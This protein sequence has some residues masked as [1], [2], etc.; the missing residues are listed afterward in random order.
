MTA[1]SMSG[2]LRR[3]NY[4]ACPIAPRYGN[5]ASRSITPPVSVS[6]T[7]VFATPRKLVSI[8]VSTGRISAMPG[9]SAIAIKLQSICNQSAINLQS[10]CNQSAINL[11]P[12]WRLSSRSGVGNQSAI[13]LQS[14]CNQSVTNLANKFSIRRG[15]SICN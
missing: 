1:L 10:I 5:S 4:N 8:G 6:A 12:I 15:Q 11:S 13:N 9:N 14:I 2:K 3:A 7:L